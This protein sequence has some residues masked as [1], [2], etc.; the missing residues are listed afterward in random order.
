MIAPDPVH[1]FSFTSTTL[2][3]SLILYA[4]IFEKMSNKDLA[5]STASLI[6]SKYLYVI[7]QIQHKMSNNKICKTNPLIFKSIMMLLFFIRNV[8][9]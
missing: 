7:T 8:R 6:D 5:V 2:F 3:R 1:C 4:E 9:V